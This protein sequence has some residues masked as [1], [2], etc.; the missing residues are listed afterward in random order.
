MPRRTKAHDPSKATRP[1]PAEVEVRNVAHPRV[2][3]TA[4]GL[5]G[6]DRSRVRV[7]KWGKV[8]VTVAETEPTPEE[9]I[10]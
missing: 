5:A 1:K 8:E 2:W 9:P 4:I 10:E 6:G 3:A 7:E